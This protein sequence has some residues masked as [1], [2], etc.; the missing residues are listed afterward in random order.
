MS[1]HAPHAYVAGLS[2]TTHAPSFPGA[3]ATSAPATSAPVATKRPR[4]KYVISKSRE[5]WS[6]SEHAEFVTAVSA[7]GRDWKAIATRVGTKNVVQTRSHAQKWFLKVGK[8]GPSSEFVVP[9]ARAKKRRTRE[10]RLVGLPD[11]TDSVEPN[12]PTPTVFEKHYK[13]EHTLDNNFPVSPSFLEIQYALNMN[14]A[15]RDGA[16]PD[17]FN[18][19]VPESAS[20]SNSA[21]VSRSASGSHPASASASATASGS[22]PSPVTIR[23]RG[24]KRSAPSPVDQA[25]WQLPVRT[26][27]SAVSVGANNAFSPQ[28]P[29]STSSAPDFGRIY[30]CIANVVDPVGRYDPAS[31]ILHPSVLS[32]LDKEIVKILVERMETNLRDAAVRHQLIDTYRM[33]ASERM[34]TLPTT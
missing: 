2:A 5:S 28:A 20:F 33:H 3:P 4:K 34:S 13:Q 27:S 6:A 26:H 24:I 9:P 14:A 29:L 25:A 30:A 17:N 22:P 21:S 12:S 18:F 31:D 1:A 11:G 32:A 16:R 10:P 19:F 7:L 8:E 15:Q 23:T